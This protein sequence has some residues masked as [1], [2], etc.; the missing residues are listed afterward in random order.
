VL[1]GPGGGVAAFSTPF[2]LVFPP[3]QEFPSSDTQSRADPS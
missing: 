2:T 3:Y 1:S